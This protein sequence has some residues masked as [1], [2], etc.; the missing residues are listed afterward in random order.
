MMNGAPMAQ[1]RSRSTDSSPPDPSVKVSERL[2]PNNSAASTA[3]PGSV[4]ILE[5]ELKLRTHNQSS[6]SQ[7]SSS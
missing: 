4:S 6:H 7:V 2:G 1:I 3:A 5:F